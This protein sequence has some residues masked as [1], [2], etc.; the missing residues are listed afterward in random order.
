VNKKDPLKTY[1]DIAKF[2]PNYYWRDF[3]LKKIHS[4]YLDINILKNL[5]KEV[6]SI[7]SNPLDAKFDKNSS[8]LSGSSS[9]FS[10]SMKSSDI[11]SMH[12]SA[13]G[14]K[15]MEETSSSFTVRRCKQ[16]LKRCEIF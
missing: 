10:S 6:T 16:D 2:D 9:I 15:N 14:Q 11:S 12:L 13:S 4:F 7:I 1:D 3:N 5:K 8:M